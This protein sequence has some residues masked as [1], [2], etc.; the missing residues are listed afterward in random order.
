MSVAL[1]EDCD[2][3]QSETPFIVQPSKP[4]GETVTVEIGEM[5]I[6]WLVRFKVLPSNFCQ[7]TGPERSVVNPKENKMRDLC[8]ARK[9]GTG[10]EAKNSHE[11]IFR[12]LP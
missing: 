1:I 3:K 9:V 11:V 5:H 7:G 4:R 10:D 12:D 6:G 2:A 8:T